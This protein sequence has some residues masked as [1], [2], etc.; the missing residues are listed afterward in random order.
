MLGLHGL[1]S[2]TLTS[3]LVLD[4]CVL[5]VCITTHGII[6]QYDHSCMDIHSKKIKTRRKDRYDLMCDIDEYEKKKPAKEPD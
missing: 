5:L 6:L 1:S 3:G 4:N 2:T